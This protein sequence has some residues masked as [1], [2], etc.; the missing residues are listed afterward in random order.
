MSSVLL[1]FETRISAATISSLT[2]SDA[3]EKYSGCIVAKEKDKNQQRR[4][5]AV[6]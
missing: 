6:V 2:F 3:I 4:R 5:R 1:C